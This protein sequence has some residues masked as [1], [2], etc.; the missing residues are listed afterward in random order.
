[1]GK[2]KTVSIKKFEV[3]VS[4][5]GVTGIPDG[6]NGKIQIDLADS[7][8]FSGQDM[9]DTAERAISYALEEAEKTLRI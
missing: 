5:Q 3:T 1:M 7:V 2:G 6:D 9:R 8:V 4:I